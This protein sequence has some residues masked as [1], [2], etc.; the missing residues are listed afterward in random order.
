MLVGTCM[1]G[2]RVPMRHNRSRVLY[3][4]ETLLMMYRILSMSVCM[5][6]SVCEV[7]TH[8]IRPI[9]PF[10]ILLYSTLLYS[11]RPY[12]IIQH[13]ISSANHLVQSYRVGGCVQVS[14]LSLFVRSF[15]CDRMLVM[16]ARM[17]T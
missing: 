3:V 13:S 14:V 8:Y 2:A 9:Y 7:E 10:H 11:T 12:Q 1:Q 15:A 6:G 16:Y 5:Y 17:Y 4:R